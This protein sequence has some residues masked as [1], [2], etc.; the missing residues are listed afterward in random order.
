MIWT[1]GDK[2]SQMVVLPVV[3]QEIEIVDDLDEETERGN[4]GFGSSGK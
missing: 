1:D 2:I 3:R 4:N